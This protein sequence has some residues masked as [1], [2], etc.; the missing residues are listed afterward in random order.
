MESLHKMCSVTLCLYVS[1]AY[2]QVL[3]C[4]KTGSIKL[5]L[6]LALNYVQK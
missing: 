6:E 4:C 3:T 5:Y 1:P 2:L